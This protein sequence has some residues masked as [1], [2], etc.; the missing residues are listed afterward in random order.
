M[1]S[2]YI[3]KCGYKGP[4]S[5]SDRLTSASQS[6]LERQPDLLNNIYIYI[7]IIYIYI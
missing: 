2:N 7:Y 1:D 5:Q 6:V 3:T 4:A